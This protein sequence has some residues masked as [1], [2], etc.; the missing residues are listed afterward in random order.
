VLLA[1]TATHTT[2]EKSGQCASAVFRLTHTH[3]HTHTHYKYSL[4]ERQREREK[5]IGTKNES[6]FSWKLE[7]RRVERERVS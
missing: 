5:E 1:Q 4:R 3:T 7:K 2:F 6:V